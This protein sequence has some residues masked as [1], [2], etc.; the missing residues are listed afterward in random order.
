MIGDI[1]V[2]FLLQIGFTV[3]ITVLFGWLI[4]QCNRTFYRNFGRY[5]RTVCYLTGAI[6]TPLHECG[7]ALFCLLFGHKIHEIKLFQIGD[8]GTLGYVKHSY[9]KK[10]VYQRIGNFF[11]GVGPIL[12]IGAV[13]FLLAYLLLPDFVAEMVACMQIDSFT[14]DF[15]AV[16][17]GL[18]RALEMFFFSALDWRFWVFVLVGMFLALHMTL[19]KPD[20]QGAWSGILVLLAIVL[21]VDIILG[22]VGGNV[23]STVTGWVLTAGSYLLCFLVL[24]LLISLLSV[25]ASFVFRAARRR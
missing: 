23:L 6:G 2:C 16:F 7:H 8:D 22:V 14:K 19:S 10:N 3:G 25:A 17:T 4:A 9:N 5:G 1:A 15:G 20:V 13:L 12:L 11:I 18:F 21:L 24:S